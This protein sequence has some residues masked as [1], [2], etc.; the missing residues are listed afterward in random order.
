MLPRPLSV[1][2][3]SISNVSFY[4]LNPLFN[5]DH[6]FLVGKTR[7]AALL[8]A[9]ALQLHSPSTITSSRPPR[10]LAVTHSNGAADV[11]LS[12]LLSLQ[13]PAVRGGRP[14]SI[15][16]DV[17]HRS[18]SALAEHHP[19]VKDLR[20]QS[21]DAS[22]SVPERDAALRD[23]RICASKVA[24]SMMRDL[25]PVVVTSCIGAHQLLK[26]SEDDDD[27]GSNT[28]GMDHSKQPLFDLVV[29][30]EAAQTTEPSLLVAL[31]SSRAEQIIMVGDTKQLPPT[32][33]SQNVELREALGTSPM[34]RLEHL[35]VGKQMLN[36]QYR[37]KHEA[38]LQ[39]PSRYFYGGKVVSPPSPLPVK[40]DEM[41]ATEL[42]EGFPWPNDDIPLCFINV[43]KTGK[44]NNQD[45]RNNGTFSFGVD[46]VELEMTH[47]Y[48]GKSNPTEAKLAAMIVNIFLLEQSTMRTKTHASK[49][50]NN[51]ENSLQNERE[52]SSDEHSKS[53]IYKTNNNRVSTVAVITPYARQVALLR[54]EISRTSSSSIH[55]HASNSKGRPVPKKPKVQVGTI[56]SFQGQ[57]TDM[58][59][60]S[61]VRS[62]PMGDLGF[63]RDPRRLCVALTRAKKGLIVLGDAKTLRKCP[64]WRALIDSCM[65]RDCFVEDMDMAWDWLKMRRKNA[66]FVLDRNADAVIRPFVTTNATV[67]NSDL[68]SSQNNVTS[69]DNILNAL[70]Q[71]R[72]F[73]F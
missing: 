34:L 38:L 63:V 53:N 18:V 46:S 50:N 47:D 19:E 20:D 27:D 23:A 21:C 44:N 66:A 16:P 54:E 14:A 49:I 29:N 70:S 41:P 62:N 45:F 58:V 35:G 59:L 8:I 26:Q 1:L 36:M 71:T 52:T 39:F 24:E 40:N 11:L 2:E 17:Q 28:N 42:P 10:I 65:E 13:I 31:A 25:A 4:Y 32:V 3:E 68:D 73:H 72:D 64:S 43:H 30:D 6:F 22:L 48:G 56:D 5:N 67:T 9:A 37:M 69:S 15:S 51:G 7:L 61:T 57:E 55:N 33:T 60:L 12:S